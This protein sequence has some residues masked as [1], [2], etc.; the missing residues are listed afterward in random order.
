MRQRTDH[1]YTYVVEPLPK[2]DGCGYI[3]YHPELGRR[4]VFAFGDTP[5]SA[6]A[7][8][9]ASRMIWLECDGCGQAE[10]LRQ[11]LG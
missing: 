5:E 10:G 4:K 7:R 3:A 9:D 11:F 6:I 8:L 1:D 2:E